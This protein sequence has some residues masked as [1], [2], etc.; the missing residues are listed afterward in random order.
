MMNIQI[1]AQL[2]H[3]SKTDNYKTKRT[4]LYASHSIIF[5]LYDAQFIHLCSNLFMI[6]FKHFQ[7]S[8]KLTKLNHNVSNCTM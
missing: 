3:S 7:N 8:L 2:W 4:E 1:P 6:E 5:E